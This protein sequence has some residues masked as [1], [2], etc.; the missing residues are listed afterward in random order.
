MLA[1]KLFIDDDSK[2]LS[3]KFYI[4]IQFKPKSLKIH[5]KLSKHFYFK[6]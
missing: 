3:I 1:L 6:I 4:E 2:S 5:E